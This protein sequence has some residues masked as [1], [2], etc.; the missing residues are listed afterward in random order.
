MN[1]EVLSLVI[2]LPILI[3]NNEKD[4]VVIRKTV[5]FTNIVYFETHVTHGDME[6][7]NVRSSPVGENFQV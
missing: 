2:S 4:F 1:Q 5:H 7:Y 3:T 6:D